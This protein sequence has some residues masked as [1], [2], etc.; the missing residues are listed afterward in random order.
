MQKIGLFTIALYFLVL[1]IVMSPP[2]KAW[3]EDYGQPD[4]VSS[5]VDRAEIVT[6]LSD[7]QD[8]ALME[9]RIPQRPWSGSYWPDLAGSIAARYETFV[10][11]MPFDWDTLRPH[12]LKQLR[13]DKGGRIPKKYLHNLSPAT[14]YDLFVGD[15]DFTLTNKAIE[16][17]DHLVSE[18]TDKKWVGICH[19][20]APASLLL[21]RPLHPVTV[22]AGNGQEIEFFPTDIK[23]LASFLWAESFAQGYV[24]VEGYQC[25]SG[26]H[27]DRHHRET[28]PNCFDVNPGF[29]HLTLVNQ[30]G[31]NNTGLII[32]KSHK[33]KVANQPVFAYS[34]RFFN[35]LTTKHSGSLEGSTVALTPDYDD[36]FA[37]YR[38]TRAKSIVGVELSMWYGREET[39][40]HEVKVDTN[41]TPVDRT[42]KMMVHYDLELDDLGNIV[43][44]EWRKHLNEDEPT[45]V[46]YFKYGHPDIVWLVPQGLKAWS[47]GD[48]D[49]GD[50]TWDE[51]GRPTNI[52]EDAL[53]AAAVKA[54]LATYQT[55]THSRP[56]PQPLAKVVD[57][58]IERSQ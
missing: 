10:F 17:I 33:L 5:F 7:M 1:I 47:V 22:L 24:K 49:L 3:A 9:H 58:L 13:T 23:A 44:G 42:G 20:W 25:R 8:L 30:L 6:R 51:Q 11:K 48:Y 29:F 55:E 21:N 50:V 45:L 38:S 15:R 14:K 2:T 16:R 31:L 19:G 28:D 43:G 41:G 32:D 36:P 53:T 52:S 34:Y 54:S 39:P 4:K 35:P 26:A 18:G 12:A 56:N 46:E 40:R 37:K 57:L 27:E